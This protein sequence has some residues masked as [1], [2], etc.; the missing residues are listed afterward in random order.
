[1]ITVPDDLRFYLKPLECT[2]QVLLGRCSVY[3]A[4]LAADKS[5]E[6][7]RSVSAIND[8]GARDKGG[9]GKLDEF[10]ARQR[11]GRRPTEQVNPTLTNRFKSV[12][13]RYRYI[14]D[15]DGPLEP[16]SDYGGYGTT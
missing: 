2:G 4:N 11:F 12:L 9:N 14:G 13:R 7:A 6:A 1:M 8:A 16:L 15:G 10:A 3:N 5:A